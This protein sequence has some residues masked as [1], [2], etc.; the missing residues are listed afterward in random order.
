MISARLRNFG[1]R[2]RIRPLGTRQTRRPGRRHW[3][4]GSRQ[5]VCLVRIKV[6]GSSVNKDLVH[7]IHEA[8]VGK[9]FIAVGGHVCRPAE[10]RGVHGDNDQS[11]KHA[12]YI[13]LNGT[14]ERCHQCLCPRDALVKGHPRI[15]A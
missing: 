12:A 1:W 8:I 13:L 4:Q 14:L 9:R 2:R 10:V 15:E 6:N 7:V 11:G 3:H 5:S